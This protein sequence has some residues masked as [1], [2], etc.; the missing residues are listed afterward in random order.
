MIIDNGYGMK[1]KVEKSEDNS[2]YFVYHWNK[3]N[4]LCTGKWVRNTG[5]QFMTQEQA[6][7]FVNYLCQ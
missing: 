7:R 6:V 4:S 2:E 3:P 1:F 5:D